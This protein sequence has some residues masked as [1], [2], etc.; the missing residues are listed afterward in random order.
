[1]LTAL[2]VRRLRHSGLGKRMIAV[3]DNEPSAASIGISPGVT[4]LTA[5]MISGMI[6]SFGGFLYGGL[7]VNFS[8]DINGTFGASQSLSLVVMTVFG[9][10]PYELGILLVAVADHEGVTVVEADVVDVDADAR[11]PDAHRLGESVD[12][13][14]LDPLRACRS[15]PHGGQA[16]GIARCGIMGRL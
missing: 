9:G 7:L 11:S 10:A 1:M 3:R 5:F 2:V 6:A 12:P 8:G 16:A 13:A 4:K 15:R 14:I